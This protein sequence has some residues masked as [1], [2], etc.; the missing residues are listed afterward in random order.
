MSTVS[1]SL[2]GELEGLV[3]DLQDGTDPVDQ[4]RTGRAIGDL[5]D[6]ITGDL[7]RQAN[8]QGHTWRAIGAQLGVPFQ[9]L[10]RRY[11]TRSA[12]ARED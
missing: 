5:A 3:V 11:G 1:R 7:V 6:R 9:T 4:A 10:H 12:E 8:R 2:I